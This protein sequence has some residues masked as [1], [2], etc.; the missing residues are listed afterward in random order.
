MSTS[1]DR[2]K[3][4]FLDAGISNALPSRNAAPPPPPA[5]KRPKERMTE[6]TQ[7]IENANSQIRK[8]GGAQPES[9]AEAKQEQEGGTLPPSLMTDEQVRLL[10]E[11]LKSVDAIKQP[12]K[13]AKKQ[14][15]DI[16]NLL[17][18]TIAK[19]EDGENIKEQFRKIAISQKD[20]INQGV[21]APEAL[22]T[23][24]R[25]GAVQLSL[26]GKKISMSDLMAKALIAYI[27][28][29]MKDLEGE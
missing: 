2:E 25:Q 8:K 10:A 29:I 14:K 21:S 16:A 13:K 6:D 18:Q 26:N 19:S 1:S 27:P 11:M 23:I 7:S 28:E 5:L 4:S 12:E 20:K 9:N 17:L 24:Y 3:M 22:F 15:I